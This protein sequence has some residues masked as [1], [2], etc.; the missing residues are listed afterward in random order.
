MT[1]REASPLS[2]GARLRRRRAASAGAELLSLLAAFVAVAVLV[3]VVVSIF[4]KGAGALSVHLF[5]RTPVPFG[6]TGGGIEQALIGTAELVALATSIALPAGVLVAV[7]AHE[8]APAGVARLVRLCLNVLAGVPTIVVGILVFTLVVKGSGQSGWAGALAL[9]IIMVPLVARGSEEVLAVVP[10]TL[11]EASLALGATRARTVLRVVLPT[12][13]G[14]IVTATILAVAR[15]AGETAPLLFTSS[16]AAT[17][18]NT[19]PQRP[20]ASVAL[21]IFADS[22]SPDPHAHQEAWAAAFVLLVFV[23]AISIGARLV[24]SRARGGRLR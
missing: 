5:T 11:R 4:L 22:E 3:V 19:D 24:A 12:A 9:S 14:G 1:G 13:V 20:L 7:Y 10:A 16:I 6:E 8:F 18:V 23:L 15:V 2:G 17:T 21:S